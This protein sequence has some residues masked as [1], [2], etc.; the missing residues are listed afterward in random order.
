MLEL[1]DA[2]SLD[3]LALLVLEPVRL[4]DYAD[5]PVD[6]TQQLAVGDDRL[7]RRHQH[8]ELVNARYDTALRTYTS[9]LALHCSM[10]V[11]SEWF[12]TS[13]SAV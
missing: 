1:E 11:S 8:V 10:F 3:E 9:K 2:Q 5:S 7:E 4:V 6:L 13:N 12:S